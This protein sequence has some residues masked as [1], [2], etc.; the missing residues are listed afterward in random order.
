MTNNAS[1]IFHA[2]VVSPVEVGSELVFQSSFS[3]AEKSQVP[4]NSASTRVTL[5]QQ[6]RCYSRAEISEPRSC[7]IQGFTKPLW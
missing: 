5:K 2:H 3:L 1:V 4:I 6:V 7:E